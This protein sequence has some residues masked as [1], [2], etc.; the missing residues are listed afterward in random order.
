MALVNCVV[1]CRCARYKA[2]A[3]VRKTIVSL[4]AGELNTEDVR[5]GAVGQV[6]PTPGGSA[7]AQLRGLSHVHHGM[8]MKR[9]SAGALKANKTKQE[10]RKLL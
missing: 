7:G 3:Q 5:R 6:H 10:L 1:G 8:T 2:C 4:G 9:F